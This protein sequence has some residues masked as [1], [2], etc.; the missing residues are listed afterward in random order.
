MATGINFLFCNNK[1]FDFW[2]VTFVSIN[3]NINI[4]PCCNDNINENTKLS[5]YLVDI[6]YIHVNK[7][8]MKAAET[9]IKACMYVEILTSKTS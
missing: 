3:D 2:L 7:F 1:I 5:K 9:R 4:D 6:I 8:N